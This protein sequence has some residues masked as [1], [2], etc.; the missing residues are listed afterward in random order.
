[1]LVDSSSKLLQ[2]LFEDGA[3]GELIICCILDF[4]FLP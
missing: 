4:V 1:L 3:T 2:A